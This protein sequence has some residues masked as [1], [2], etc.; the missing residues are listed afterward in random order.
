MI[1]SCLESLISAYSISF[2]FVKRLLFQL[3]YIYFRPYGPPCLDRRFALRT[4]NAGNSQQSRGVYSGAE[5]AN[6][7]YQRSACAPDSPMIQA[8]VTAH[9]PWPSCQGQQH[10]AMFKSCS[11]E[12]SLCGLIYSEHPGP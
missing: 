3:R 6:Q 10:C 11:S 5:A 1:G 9:S 8:C 4:L 2:G 12:H 7:V